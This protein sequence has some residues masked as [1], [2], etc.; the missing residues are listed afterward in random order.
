MKAVSM[1]ACPLFWLWS[2][3]D[4]VLKVQLKKFHFHLLFHQDDDSIMYCSCCCLGNPTD[5]DPD[6]VMFATVQTLYL[7]WHV[8]S[9][10]SSIFKLS[11]W[12]IW[13]T[14]SSSTITP[15]CIK[16]NSIAIKWLL[17]PRWFPFVLIKLFESSEI[18]M[19]L[20]DHSTI[21]L[22]WR[23]TTAATAYFGDPVA[24]CM[25]F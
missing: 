16:D 12:C 8:Q 5:Y 7:F 10:W 3:F 14:Q 20:N 17:L 15:F 13:N 2:L 21:R 25:S 23:H 4:L 9:S 18:E 19:L 6:L 22:L 11:W 24:A 1:K